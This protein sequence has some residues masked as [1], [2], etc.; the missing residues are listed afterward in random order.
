MKKYNMFL[1]KRGIPIFTVW[2]HEVHILAKFIPDRSIIIDHQHI[3]V[4]PVEEVL[5]EV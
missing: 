4:Q 2:K 3:L 5:Q 1:T